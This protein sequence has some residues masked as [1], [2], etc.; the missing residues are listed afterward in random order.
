M[1]SSPPQQRLSRLFFHITV[2]CHSTPL[3]C[4]PMLCRSDPSPCQAA[5]MQVSA[6]LC[7][8]RA[9]HATPT[10]CRDSLCRCISEQGN[11]AA[12]LAGAMPLR[13]EAIRSGAVAVPCF[14]LPLR[15]TSVPSPCKSRH[16]ISFA[17]HAPLCSCGARM[18]G[19]TPMR[20]LTLLC[21]CADGIFQS[22]HCRCR[23]TPHA[24][25]PLQR[26]FAEQI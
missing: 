12:V 11:S 22:L 21:H 1:V 19:A 9:I 15:R 25:L 7:R 2:P 16:I 24:A 5:A 4:S 6:G 17:F 10:P 23:P 3:R 8:C 18:N 13:A 26:N 20:S 14:P